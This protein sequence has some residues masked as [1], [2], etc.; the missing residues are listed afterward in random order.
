[1]MINNDWLQAHLATRVREYRKGAFKKDPA[2]RIV[3]ASG[4]I[5]SVQASE[6]HYCTPKANEGPYVSV[7]VWGGGLT[8]DNQ[9]A[10]SGNGRVAGEFEDS[11]VGWV[12]TAVVIEVINHEGGVK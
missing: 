6:T 4:A 5:L 8:P 2:K 10:L 9:A 1:M 11:P 7:E 3:C 12:D